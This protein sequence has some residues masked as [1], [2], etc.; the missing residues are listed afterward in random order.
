MHAWSPYLIASPPWRSDTNQS[1]LAGK[2]TA[3]AWSG[4]RAFAVRWCTVR[5]CGVDEGSVRASYEVYQRES[6]EWA[7]WGVRDV[8]TQVE[9]R[10]GV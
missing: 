3:F 2:L 6:V 4:G 7:M 8:G 10:R 9:E 1:S 5:G